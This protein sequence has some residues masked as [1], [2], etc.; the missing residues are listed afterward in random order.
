MMGRDRKQALKAGV[1]AL[2]I[3][4]DQQTQGAEA[5]AVRLRRIKRAGNRNSPR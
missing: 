4:D 5:E 2:Q 1:A 3:A